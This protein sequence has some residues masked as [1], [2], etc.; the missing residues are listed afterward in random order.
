MPPFQESRIL[1]RDVIHE[2]VDDNLQM[3]PK[4][5][6]RKS[7]EIDYKEVWEQISNFLDDEIA[8]GLRAAMVAHFKDCA[9]AIAGLRPDLAMRE[10]F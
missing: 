7:I 2:R 6:P 5:L 10:Q 8:P 4:C 1:V 3:G 9:P